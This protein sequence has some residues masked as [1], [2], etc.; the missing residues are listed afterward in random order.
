MDKARFQNVLRRAF[1][2]PLGVAAILAT[3][4]IV[5]VRSLVNSERWVERTDQVIQAAE[6][7]YRV[8]VD[9]ET[10]LRAYLLTNDKR[11]LQPFYDGRHEAHALEAQL[12]QM[13]ADNPEQRALNQKAFL[14]YEDWLSFADEAIAET[15]AGEDTS[16]VKFQ[17]HGKEL[18]DRVRQARSEFITREEQFRNER[19]ASSHRT[20]RF[21][22]LSV[23]TL[24]ILLGAILA[25]FARRQ[26]M[27]LSRAF[28]LALDTAQASAAEARAQREWLHTTL[29]SIGDAVIATDPEG[30][31]TFMNPVAEQLTGWTSG[32]AKGRALPQVFRIINEQTREIVEN[33]VD[34]VRRQ[35]RI[36]GL[37]NHTLL[38]SRTGQEFAIDDSGAPIR[39]AS[40]NMAG[41][42][43]VF[44]DVTQQRGLEAALQ[45]NERLAVAGRLSAS[46]AHEIH[47]PLD[48][49]GNLLFLIGQQTAGQAQVQQ[50]IGTAQR[51]VHRVAQIS[52]NMLSLQRNSKSQSAV[53]LS[54]LL[55]GVVALI[56]E[57]I[58]KGRRNIRIEHGFPGEIEGFAAELRQVFTNVIKN[59]VE[60]TGE[61]GN[62][63]IFSAATREA[64]RDG[65]LIHVVDDGVGIS[66]E[67]QS[68][69]FSPFV[70]TKQ[71]SGSGL[72]LWV[73]RSILEK[74]GGTIRISS[75]P[76][77]PNRGT[78]VSIFLPLEIAPALSAA[79]IEPGVVAHVSVPIREVAAG[80]PDGPSADIRKRAS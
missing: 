3:T 26:L 64:G 78:T 51:E 55:D 76:D 48:T 33:P 23:V 40:G 14:A 38:I 79:E 13:V 39:D 4:L 57:T 5:E 60:A 65:V 67:M 22:N 2:V 73:S 7:L 63:K 15:K 19:L 27:S 49:V 69:L 54:E 36:V 43:L 45:S 68:K 11:F 28:G 50:L 6:T 66:A 18:M 80:V 41:V 52:K 77:A 16:E 17:L 29:T 32:E 8:K 59:A 35:N 20:L 58:A 75:T 70:S 12:Q 56:D 53:K 71:E 1:L 21:V 74:H 9:Q 34:K 46:I 25:A 72:G 44:R 30:V 24:C 10:A 47:N 37:A 42:V 61:G 31:I 62:I